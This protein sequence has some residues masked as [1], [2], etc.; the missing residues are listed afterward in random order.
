MG[1]YPRCGD[2]ITKD[3]VDKYY[4]FE[5]ISDPPSS[6][7]IRMRKLPAGLVPARGKGYATEHVFE[8]QLYKIF[9][10]WVLMMG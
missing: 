10:E 5:A 7:P 4:G 2:A 8:P 3:E 9:F 6:C 1:N